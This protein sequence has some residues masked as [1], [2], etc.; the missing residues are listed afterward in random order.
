[1]RTFVLWAAGLFAATGLAQQPGVF[2]LNREYSVTPGHS[3]AASV[4]DQ[5]QDPSE[6]K[7]F[8]AMYRKLP[9]AG[10]REAGESFVRQFPQSW[11]LAQA[12]EIVAKACIDQEDYRCALD[13]GRASLR[14]QPE[15]PLLLVPLSNVQATTG[16]NAGAVENAR[17]AL[18]MLDRFRHPRLFSDKAWDE[19]ETALRASANYVIG[20]ATVSDAM[21]SPEPQKR[22]KLREADGYLSTAL[23]LAPSDDRIAYILGLARILELRSQDAAVSFAS[24]YGQSGQF[25]DKIREHLHKLYSETPAAGRPPFETYVQQLQTA[26][27]DA[28][29]RSRAAEVLHT[30]PSAYAG[31]ASCR[32]CHGKQYSGWQETGHA[33]MFRAY[34]FENVIGDFN[35]RSFEDD[36]GQV[37]ARMTIKDDQ[38]YFHV[39]GA[40]KEWLTY[41]IDY[42]IG[43]KWQQ[44]YATKL[45]NGEIHVFPLQYNALQHK[46]V[47]FWKAIDPPGTPRGEPDNFYR[48]STDTSY[49][50]NCAPCHTSQL[51]KTEPGPATPQNATFRE[52]GINCEACHGPSVAHVEAMRAAKP[53]RT[54][55]LQL[56]EFGKVSARDYV[57]FC[58]VCHMQ[59]AERD[60][61]PNGECNFRKTGDTFFPRYRSTPYT[62][63]MKRAFYKDGRFRVV[64]FISEAFVR[65][66]CYRKGEAHCGHCHELHPDNARTNDKGLKAE[67]LS[68]PDGMCL[69]CHPS[70][71]AG[72]QSHTHHAA[73]SEGSRCVS[74]HMPKNMNT[75]LFK[76][77][78]HQIDEIPDAAMTA[79]FGQ[80]DSPNACLTCHK[81]KDTDWLG[82]T[83]LEWYPARQT[84][85]GNQRASK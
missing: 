53:G 3:G 63:F 75:V 55:P 10:R 58:S 72:I 80:Q 30:P 42:T 70:F 19:E 7:A 64:S 29:P 68:N 41:K 78:S 4:L 25:Q 35:D 74:C 23:E 54:P 61:G 40:R 12:W 2:D 65:T 77:M 36:K 51:S 50:M 1:M 45:P 6:R 22:Q 8:E 24:V 34:Q 11:Y 46:W 47:A 73:A 56:L 85:S 27:R 14:L 62:E 43:S 17:D 18:E 59:S 38:H 79:R 13:A 39:R 69:Q 15:N 33:R 82:R 57:A 16:D 60:Y 84:A 9:P 44:T 21:R 67:F 76:A 48:D 32:G 66:A 20:K 31:S 81:E 37:V 26:A 5:I 28:A 83:M 71:A 49:L 52:G